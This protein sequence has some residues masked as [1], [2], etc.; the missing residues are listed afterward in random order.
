MKNE[1]DK[2]KQVTVTFV[3]FIVLPKFVRKVRFVNVCN[4]KAMDKYNI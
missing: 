4:L 1:C 2:E 3:A